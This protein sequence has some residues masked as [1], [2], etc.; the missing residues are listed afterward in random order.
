MKKRITC[1][2]IIFHQLVLAQSQWEEKWSIPCDS[3]TVWDIDQANNSFVYSQNNLIKRDGNG[4]KISEQSIKSIGEI[5]KIDASN[6]FK[7]AV[8]SEN[9]QQICFLD[10]ALAIQNEC[11]ELTSFDIHYAETFSY[12]AQN[13]RLWVYDQLNSTLKLIT[14]ESMKQQKIQNLRSL[15]QFTAIDQL[16]ERNNELYLVTDNKK[17]H[18]FDVF[19]SYLGTVIVPNSHWI[20][21]WKDGFLS[22]TANEINYVESSLTSSIPFFLMLPDETT[23]LS[24]KWQAASQLLFVQTST[25]LTCFQFKK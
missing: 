25:K 1:L 20:Q 24:F 6:T 5:T 8:F 21:A 22:A 13:D 15:I 9:Q 18:H 7:I 11:I 17:I 12:T 14:L 2:L 4:K 3:T 23:I 19:G 16:F 10:N